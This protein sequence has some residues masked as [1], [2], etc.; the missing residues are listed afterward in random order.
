MKGCYAGCSILFSE[1]RGGDV[2]DCSPDGA[3]GEESSPGSV[4]MCGLGFGFQDSVL[5]P[6][7]AHTHIHSVFCMLDI[8]KHPV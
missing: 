5:F 7:C 8:W 1:V 3:P 6:A 2:F 4:Q